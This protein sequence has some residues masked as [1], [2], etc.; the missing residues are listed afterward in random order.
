MSNNKPQGIVRRIISSAAERLAQ[1]PR[2]PA[3]A[4]EAFRATAVSVFEQ[5][6]RDLIGC[7]S[8]LLTGWRV[9][10]SDRQARRQ[11][12]EMA[13]RSGEPAAAIAAR[14]RVTAAWVR[15]LAAQLKGD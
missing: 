9:T 8:V 11:R 1:D 12:I 3:D 4:R 10:P 15:M 7:D 2:I 13:I 5:Q 14:E 6:V